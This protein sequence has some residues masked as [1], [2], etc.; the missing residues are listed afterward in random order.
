MQKKTKKKTTLS[1]GRSDYRGQSIACL[2][3]TRPLRW[4]LPQYHANVMQKNTK[5]TPLGRLSRHRWASSNER[6][7]TI[8][9]DT[10]L[11]FKLALEN[12]QNS[13]HQKSV[14]KKIYKISSHV[15]YKFLI[16]YKTDNQKNVPKIHKNISNS[17][18]YRQGFDLDQFL[19]SNRIE[20]DRSRTISKFLGDLLWTQEV[21][22][23]FG[24]LTK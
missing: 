23:K 1:A 16:P 22:G 10:Q 6:E 13:K 15:C 11:V 19:R 17:T 2:A 18:E 5:I 14:K 7:A 21:F 4:L 9:R 3:G 8:K 12:N 20:L 24:S